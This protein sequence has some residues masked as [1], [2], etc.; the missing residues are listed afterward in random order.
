MTVS[1]IKENEQYMHWLMF[2][3]K[4]SAY[5]TI[6]AKLCSNR[7]D[8]MCWSCIKESIRFDLISFYIMLMCMDKTDSRFYSIFVPRF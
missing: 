4:R 8:W 2:L 3:R 5:E 7:S 6:F 1:F